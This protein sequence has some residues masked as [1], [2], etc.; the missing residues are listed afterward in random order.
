LFCFVFRNYVFVV[1]G[2]IFLIITDVIFFRIWI[3]LLKRSG[4]LGESY[5]TFLQLNYKFLAIT[6]VVLRGLLFGVL[7]SVLVDEKEG[8][9]NR[10]V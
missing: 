7:Y 1:S 10:R 8:E 3:H 2:G 5:S 4:C 9:K 6:R